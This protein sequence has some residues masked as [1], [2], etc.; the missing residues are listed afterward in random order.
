MKKNLVL[1]VVFIVFF[2]AGFYFLNKN[3][4]ENIEPAPVD[5]S[6]YV[7][8]TQHK[9]KCLNCHRGADKEARAGI[10]NID[11]CSLCHSKIINPS[12][13][14]EKQVYYFVTNNKTIPWQNYYRV[15]DFV[16][17]S[18][19]RHVKIGKLDCIQCHIDM[20][21]QTSPVIKKFKPVEMQFCLDCHKQR[22][23]TTDCGN[24]HH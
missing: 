8:T 24:C 13:V 18:H 11:M 2:I 19:R 1:I 17:F 4:K 9:I 10:P 15:P 3:P 16:Y 6:H 14:K 12:S 7:H 5:F 21:E 23:I 20:S 22:N